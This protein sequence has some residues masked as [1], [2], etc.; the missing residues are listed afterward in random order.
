MQVP[1]L[2]SSFYECTGKWSSGSTMYL[3]SWKILLDPQKLK[4][5]WNKKFNFI[6][7]DQIVVKY[8]LK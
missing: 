5:V 6:I 7:Y 4:E 8:K 2:A 1:N 3:K